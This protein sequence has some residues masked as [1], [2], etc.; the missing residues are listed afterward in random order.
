MKPEPKP[1]V[2]AEKAE[3][4]IAR[5]KGVKLKLSCGHTRII[6]DRRSDTIIIY[7]SGRAVCHNCGY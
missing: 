5:N 2:P 3:D 6:G 1:H 7:A 4:F